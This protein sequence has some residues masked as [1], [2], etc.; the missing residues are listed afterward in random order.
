MQ[1]NSQLS[2]LNSQL[3]LIA[4]LL[5]MSCSGYDRENFRME[6]GKKY[7]LKKWPDSAYIDTLERFFANEPIKQ[8]QKQK[9]EI[10]LSAGYKMAE[11]PKKETKAEQQKPKERT[12][13]K[14]EDVRKNADSFPDRFFNALFKLSENP[15][16]KEFGKKYKAKDGETLDDLLLRIY[17]TKVKKIPKQL[18]ETMIKKLNPGADFS[19][20]SEG[21]A[22]LLPTVN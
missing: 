4:A 7:N 9:A 2:T 22:I 5:L 16:S 21:E 17:G 8:Q 18:S 15:D 3:I 6:V 14:T 20:L 12:D 13:A 1:N 10:T 19:S 11:L